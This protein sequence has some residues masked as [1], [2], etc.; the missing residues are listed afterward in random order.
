MFGG[1]NFEASEKIIVNDDLNYD[2]LNIYG[3]NSGYVMIPLKLLR[4]NKDKKIPIIKDNG[5]DYD[6]TVY[7]TLS[8]ENKIIL[9]GYSGADISMIFIYMITLSNNII[10]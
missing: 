3:T 6:G 10:L 9:E 2:T 4:K 1:F 7:C 5:K 8:S